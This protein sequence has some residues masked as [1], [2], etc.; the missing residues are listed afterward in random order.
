[1][2]AR[3]IH[4]VPVWLLVGCSAVLNAQPASAS[5]VDVAEGVTAVS[6]RVSKDYFRAKL[7]DGSF[8]PEEYAFGE[9]GRLDGSFRDASI[10][11]LKFLDIA[12]VLAGP[13]ADQQYRPAKDMDSEKLLIM[14]YWGTTIVPQSFSTSPAAEAFGNAIDP[15]KWAKDPLY[16]ALG[17]P[18][19]M[20]TAQRDQ[21]DIKNALLLGYNA[22]VVIGS[23]YGTNVAHSGATGEHNDELLSEIEEN[24]YVVV[25]LAYD[26][27][28]FRKENKHKLLWEAR[29]CINEPRNDFAKALPVMAQYA[30]RYFGQD[31]HGLLR[32]KV[33]EGKV[34]IGEPRS[35]G[36]IEVPEK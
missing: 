6:S 30:S 5:S 19:L 9:G 12:R 36:E 4:Q 26:F 27:Q 2:I 11:K 23:D 14:V 31:S 29:F 32:T 20:E 1:M 21:L 25:L 10:D 16:R 22:D 35:L 8:Q 33:P 34:L 13:L 15:V 24:R 18:L 7:P 3:R 17:T 28:V